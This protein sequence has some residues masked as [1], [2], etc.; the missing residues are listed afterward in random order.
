M[1]QSE[2][3]ILAR[4][5]AD[6]LMARLAPMTEELLT[7]EQVAQLLKV[8]TPWVRAHTSELPHVRIGGMVRFPKGKVLKHVIV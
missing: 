2:A 1:T 8:S 6:E 7:A 5:I 4:A 3:R